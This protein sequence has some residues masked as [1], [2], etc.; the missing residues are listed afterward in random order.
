MMFRTVSFLALVVFAVL[1][2]GR[3][4]DATYSYTANVGLIDGFYSPSVVESTGSSVIG[5]NG[6]TESN[7]VTPGTTRANAFDIGLRS[8][9]SGTSA[10]FFN[11]NLFFRISI[12]NNGSTGALLFVENFTG[13]SV[14]VRT[15]S[16]RL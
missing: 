2:A 8:S 7:L 11:F 15:T 5:F 14:P 3:D 9:A 6:L 1:C 13:P 4:A 10:D 12:T 16:S